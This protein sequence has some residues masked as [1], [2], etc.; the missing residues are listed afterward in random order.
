MRECRDCQLCCKLLPVKELDKKANTRCKFQKIHKGCTV[1][2]TGLMPFSCH[3]WNCRWLVEDD[4]EELSRPDRSHYVIDIMPDQILALSGD[5]PYAIETVQIWC[6]PNYPDAHED[7]K[8]R[9]YLRR[10][11]KEGIVGQVR[12]GSDEAI[13][14]IPPNM[15]ETKDWIIKDGR[16][17]K[18]KDMNQILRDFNER[19]I[20]IKRM[21][22]RKV[23]GKTDV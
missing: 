14:I 18:A 16:M 7:P 12:Y 1:H 17:D 19:G 10:R 9:E 15:S 3:I 5:I 11:G 20:E 13:I 4:T 8:L 2:N 6:D 21:G 23:K 22:V